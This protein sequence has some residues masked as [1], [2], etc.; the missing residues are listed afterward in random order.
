VTAKVRI[1]ERK[2][3]EKLVF[4]LFF[5]AKVLSAQPEVRI[6]ERKTKEKLVFLLFFRAKVSS[7]GIP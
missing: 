7:A 2:T 5:R 6:S 3:K 1:S 4:L